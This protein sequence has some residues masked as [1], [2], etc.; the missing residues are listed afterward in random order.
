MRKCLQQKKNACKICFPFKAF[1]NI[2]HAIYLHAKKTL[3]NK[4]V[5]YIVSSYNTGHMTDLHKP[6]I[7]V[8]INTGSGCPMSLLIGLRKGYKDGK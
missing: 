7:V 2:R 6:Q 5:V 4:T 3:K 8:S 1:Y